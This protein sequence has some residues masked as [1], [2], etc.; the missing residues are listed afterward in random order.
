MLSTSSFIEQELL[1]HQVLALEAVGCKDWLTSKVD[2]SVTGRVAMQQCAGELQLP[3]N[4]LGV[5]ALDYRGARG[6]ATSIG[7]APAAGLISAEAGARLSIA[8]A[9]TNLVWAPIAGGLRGVSLS[10]NWMWPCRSAGEDARLYRAVKAASDFAQALGVNIPTGKDS[11]SMTQ[12]YPDGRQVLAPGTVIISTVGEVSDV[13][14]VVSPVLRPAPESTLLYLNLSRLPLTLGGSSAAQVLDEQEAAAPDVGNPAYFAAAFAAVQE[15]V[16]KGMVLAGHD[17]SAGGLITT[18][19]EMT[20]ANVEGGVEVDIT[21]LGGLQNALFAEN[22]AVVL[23]VPDAA[24]AKELLHRHG[25]EAVA[26]GAPIPARSL[27]LFHNGQKHKLD[28]DALR[29]LWYKPSFLLDCLQSGEGKAQERYAGYKQQPVRWRLPQRFTGK[30][31]QYGL[32]PRGGAAT[33]RRPLAAVLREKGSQCERE[34][35]WALHLAGFDVRD[36]HTTDLIAGREGLE[37]VRLLVFVGGFS[38]SDVLGSA[39]GWAGALLFNPSAKQAL[40]RFYA[41]PDT[42]SLGIC[43]GCQLMAELGVLAP[44]PVRLLHNDSR[45]FESAFVGVEVLPGASVMLRPLA[46]ATLG[47]WVA[48]GEGTFDLPPAAEG[49]YSVALRYAYDAYPAN[50]NGSPNAVAGVCSADGRHL[51]MMPHPERAV[52]PWTCAYVPDLN[53]QDEV[54]PWIEMFVSAREWVEART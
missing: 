51:A 27:R 43:N 3:L 16:E 30:L 37:D 45:K 29:D 33:G 35:A 32:D 36:V 23:Q 38:N 4:N 53:R 44:A 54:T 46:G 1:L 42:L 52:H 8:E 7:H 6:V 10:A 34:T 15:L 17:V 20:F 22:P 41:R 31:A 14:R 49:G 2:R 18:L 47:V 50:P 11:L 28:V 25:V 48:H 12:K 24:L 39:K 19:L 21:P 5:V 26:I 13:R 9:L 40:D